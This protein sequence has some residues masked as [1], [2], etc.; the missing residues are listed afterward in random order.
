[1][2]TLS[3]WIIKKLKIQK[4]VDE[5]VYGYLNDIY[6]GK[7]VKLSELKD[8]LY[9][10]T[11]NQTL[12][13]GNVEDLL[14]F[15]KN[16]SPSNFKSDDTSIFW[17]KAV[18]D[19][20]LPKVH[21]PLTKQ[22][23][24]F[25]PGLLFN[26]P[27]RYS[28]KTTAKSLSNNLSQIVSDVLESNDF[29]NMIKHG[30]VLESYSGAI[31]AKFIVDTKFSDEPIIILYPKNSIRVRYAYDKVY[32][33]VFLDMYDKG[34]ETYR[35]ESTYGKGY[36]KYKLFDTVKN[37]E[38]PLNTIDET[39]NLVDI[40]ITQNGK[41]YN[42]LLCAY[43]VNKPG[44]IEGE[45]DYNGLYSLQEALD[46]LA[47]Y[48]QLYFKYGS[49][50]K[51]VVTEDQLEKDTEGNTII[52]DYENNGLDILVLK[53][54]N[55]NGTD[56]KRDT[57]V[58]TL[59]QQAFEDAMLDI[60]KKI[61]NAVGLSLVSFG[62]EQSGRNASALQLEIR[63]AAN[64]K[65]REKKLSLWEQFICDMMELCLVYKAVMADNSGTNVFDIPE[66]NYSYV[67]QFPDYR[68][69]SFLE[70]AQEAQQLM[71]TGMVSYEDCIRL[72]YNDILEEK[73]LNEKVAEMTA[74]HEANKLSMQQSISDSRDPNQK[75]MDT[76]KENIEADAN[77]E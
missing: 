44:T 65:L 40:Y 41:P 24:D 59:S 60:S 71:A 58:P 50:V 2:G 42:K 32:E 54:R 39:S 16:Y 48:R 55:I 76:N 53:D 72:L 8:D 30:A 29:S 36:I 74:T 10:N 5:T 49:R 57:L 77:R 9:Y 27:P 37:R 64:Y 66:F 15:Y 28:I 21:I 63:E 62:L 45:S 6:N 3:E 20:R 61:V 43:K 26:N 13:E 33:I 14:F 68:V 56:N 38:V 18:L 22:I 31:A 11:L 35:L 47:S 1:M 75:Q 52:K 51:T 12:Y 7:N 25:M 67:V 46:A 69:K 73:E 4:K 34:K 70:K 19:K 17:N 23:S